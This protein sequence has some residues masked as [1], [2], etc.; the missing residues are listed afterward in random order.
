MVTFIVVPLVAGFCTLLFSKLDIMIRG[1][2]A[3]EPIFKGS[4]PE[5]SQNY[6]LS[7]LNKQET[8][9]KR[10]D[11]PEE[12]E[13][14]DADEGTEE[15]MGGSGDLKVDAPVAAAEETDAQLTEEVAA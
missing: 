8:M 4:Q 12:G 6:H 9:D 2:R 1:D 15:G 10:V 3:R 5:E 11:E 14:I 13:V 7:E